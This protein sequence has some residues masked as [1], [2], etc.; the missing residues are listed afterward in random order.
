M[1]AYYYLIQTAR[2]RIYIEAVVCVFA[3]LRAVNS[4]LLCAKAVSYP[5]VKRFFFFFRCVDLGLVPPNYLAEVARCMRKLIA[6][7]SMPCIRQRRQR[8][9]RPPLYEYAMEVNMCLDIIVYWGSLCTSIIV[10]LLKEGTYN[11]LS[12]FESMTK[13]C[14]RAGK[15]IEGTWRDGGIAPCYSALGRSIHPGRRRV[16]S[17]SRSSRSSSIWRCFKISCLIFGATIAHRPSS[18]NKPE[19]SWASLYSGSLPPSWTAI[20]FKEARKMM[21]H[22]RQYW[23]VAWKADRP[24]LRGPTTDKHLDMYREQSPTPG[25]AIMHHNKRRG[26]RPPPLVSAGFYYAAAE[27]TIDSPFFFLPLSLSLRFDCHPRK[28]RKTKASFRSISGIV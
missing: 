9:Q 3:S 6:L 17:R 14:G 21:P 16:G 20:E 23:I 5:P 1:L 24:V 19:K 13:L 28:S 2:Y 15:G 10:E 26:G 4:G 25:A 22:P 27:K 11:Y 18:E 8:R 12:L 7:I